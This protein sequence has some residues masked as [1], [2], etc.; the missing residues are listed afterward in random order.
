MLHMQSTNIR[1]LH[2]IYKLKLM[3]KYCFFEHCT[4]KITIDHSKEILK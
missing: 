2:M 1:T 3:N 4:E